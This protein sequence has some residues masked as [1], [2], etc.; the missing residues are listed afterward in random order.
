MSS[1]PSL[2]GRAVLA[3]VLMIG[4]YALAIATAGVLLYLPY[5]EVRYAK[6]LDL[7]VAVFC[8][9]GAGV[10]LWSILPRRDGFVPPGPRLAPGQHPRLFAQL[11]GVAQ[12]VGQA[13][14]AEVYLV[15]E[16]NAWVAQRGGV[17]GLGSRRVMG[18]GLPLLEIL[19]VSQLRAVLAHEFGHYYGG[20]TKLAPWVYKTRA[21]IERTLQGLA[22]AD[23]VLR[24]PFLWYGKMFLRVTHAISRQQELTA[25]ALAS[26]TVGS[27]P[28]IEGLRTIHGA[29]DA[30][31]PYWSTEAV[32]VLDAGFRPP[33]AEGFGRFVKSAAIAEAIS[34]G[35]AREIKDPKP[36]PYDTHPPLRDRI[37]AAENLPKG[38]QA[39]A[40]LAAITLLENVED[41]E[42]GLLAGMAGEAQAQALKPVR[43]ESVGVEVYLPLW[44]KSV[45]EN[46]SALQGLTP[47]SLPEISKSLVGMGWKIQ[48]P[49][50]RLPTGEERAQ[51]AQGLLGQALAVALSRQGWVLHALPGELHFQR[52]DLK[53]E[54]FAVVPKLA[55]DELKPDAWREQCAAAGISDLNLGEVGASE[56]AT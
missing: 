26:R 50:G 7:R 33:L 55:A 2:L 34:Q 31:L 25:D 51:M 6:R 14:P 36:D 16:V 19:T 39:T 48:I 47:A 53:V 52:D 12:A 22:R 9:V 46:A 38:E 54:P 32:P 29:A 20:D 42:R 21:A 43:W 27:R 35:V 28:L 18:V 44:E 5:A 10:I 11:T 56:R 15:P 40:D 23:S 24:F 45:H 1:S 4:F 37:A 49:A 8:I 17:M 30:Y 41:I 3:I 13:M